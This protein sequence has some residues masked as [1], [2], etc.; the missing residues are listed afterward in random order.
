MGP[1]NL[2]IFE[3]KSLISTFQLDPKCKTKQSFETHV[4]KM[5]DTN[6]TVSHNENF[7]TEEQNFPELEK[8]EPRRS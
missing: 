1:S 5:Y 3:D 4:Q 2:E 6:T 7:E 8:L